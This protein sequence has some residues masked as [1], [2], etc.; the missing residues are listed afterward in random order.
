MSNALRNANTNYSILSDKPLSL[1]VRDDGAPM[2]SVII[3]IYNAE[4]FLEDTLSSILNQTLRNIE[5]ICV[6]DGST[7]SSPETVERF[8]AVDERLV[9]LKHRTNKGA[10]A[11]INTGI[12]ASTGD[13]VQIVGND[14][15]LP[16]DSLENL[17][18]YC[19][20]NNLDLCLY[21]IEVFSDNPSDENLRQRLESQQQYH[22]VEFDYPICS[23]IELLKHMTRNDEYRMTNGPMIMRRDL[24]VAC[25]PCNLE[26]VRHEDMFFTYNILLKAHRCTLIPDVYYSYRVRSGSQEDGKTKN[27]HD[28]NEFASLLE[29]AYKMLSITPDN[30]LSDNEFQIVL[31]KRIL[32]Y[33]TRCAKW[34]VSY[35]D[36]ER[37]CLESSCSPLIR[38]A[39]PS[40]QLAADYS[41]S[42]S[43]KLGRA[44]SAFPRFVKRLVKQL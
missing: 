11:S 41:E 4:S 24:L 33:I 7:D 44:L 32:T 1:S 23:G 38:Y 18:G 14:D 6:D 10:G 13:Y 29:S 21:G 39:L 42:N 40:M 25:S 26:G 34:Y 36:K 27:P 22:K 3:P 5:I 20:A 8:A 15:I 31:E 37:S 2:V 17:V 16:R 35:S 19:R 43:Y 12:S 28:L 30:L 9:F